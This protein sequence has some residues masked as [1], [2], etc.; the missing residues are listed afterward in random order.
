MRRNLY[1]AALT[2]TLLTGL[3]A[4]GGGHGSPAEG[5]DKGRKAAQGDKS[6]DDKGGSAGKEGKAGGKSASPSKSPTGLPKAAD[7]TDTGACDDG[8]CEVEL[9]QGDKLRPVS[10]YGIDE[11][12]IQ[13]IEGRV[14]SWTALFSGG[15]VSMASQGT[16]TSSTTCTNGSCSGTLGKSEGTLEMNKLSVEFTAIAEDR[17]VAKVTHK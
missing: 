4:C 3:T 2:P 11:F 8:D 10:S 15:Q 17:A 6:S 16:E 7:G 9:S 13:K 5:S 12:S 14:I 1:A